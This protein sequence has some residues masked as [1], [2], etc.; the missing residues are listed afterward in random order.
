MLTAAEQ[1]EIMRRVELMMRARMVN[2]QRVKSG[3]MSQRAY[4]EAMARH[5]DGLTD[6][7]KECG[8]VPL[9]GVQNT[10]PALEADR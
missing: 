4:N 9:P 2:T 3:M 7:L 6:Y 5:R 1:D 8:D 10:A